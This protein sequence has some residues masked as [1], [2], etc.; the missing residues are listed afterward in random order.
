MLLGNRLSFLRF[1]VQYKSNACS[2]RFLNLTQ[3]SL[4]SSHP[5]NR[6]NKSD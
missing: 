4:T 3:L 5:F 1:P 2:C 6:Y